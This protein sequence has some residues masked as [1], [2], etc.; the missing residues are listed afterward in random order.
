MPILQTKVEL[1]CK[2]CSHA[3]RI[4]IDEQI[5]RRSK[6]EINLEQLLA[7]LRELGVKNPTKENV[8]LHLRRHCRIVTAEE[9]E[10]EAATKEAV[11]GRALEMCEK[12]FGPGWQERV[13][14]AD[15]F[16]ILTRIASQ[17]DIAVRM[18]AGEKTGATIDHGLKA[19][20]ETTRRRF[21]EAETDMK[22]GITKALELALAG[23]RE[24]KALNAGV[25][26]AEVVEEAEI[27]PVP[28]HDENTKALKSVGMG[29]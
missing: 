26:D 14:T 22:R 17:H 7:Y 12:E 24:R 21:N 29:G 20:G 11:S 8:T 19:V 13:L 28:D 16:L 2:L 27:E 3:E 6:R 18:A 9:A 15:E 5:E 1:K 4:R 23:G 10:A 25:I